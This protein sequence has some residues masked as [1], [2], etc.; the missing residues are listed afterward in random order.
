MVGTVKLCSI[1]EVFSYGVIQD[2]ITK[3]FIIFIDQS[4]AGIINKI[5]V[6]RYLFF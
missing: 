4:D 3:Y 2:Y 1:I 5:S 6:K